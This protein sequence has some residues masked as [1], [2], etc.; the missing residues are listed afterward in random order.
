MNKQPALPVAF[1]PIDSLVFEPH[2]TPTGG[3]T[4]SA[5]AGDTLTVVPEITASVD[6]ARQNDLL[7]ITAERGFVTVY[8]PNETPHSVRH[9]V[10]LYDADSR[11]AMF[12]AKGVLYTYNLKDLPLPA[13]GTADTTTGDLTLAGQTVGPSELDE[14]TLCEIYGL[15][16]A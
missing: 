11:L 2:P 15:G 12:S 7:R 13:Y 3:T 9:R 1:L 14:D 6:I 8:D 10:V 16:A 4:V 5:R